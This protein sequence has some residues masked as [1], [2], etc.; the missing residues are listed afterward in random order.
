MVSTLQHLFLDIQGDNQDT[1][2]GG[3]PIHRIITLHNRGDRAAYLELWVEATDQR[4]AGIVQ[5]VTF[6]KSES[7]LTLEPRQS[8]DV[9]LTITVPLQAEAGFYGYDIRLRSS[10]YPGEEV[11]RNQ[12][13]HILPSDQEARL[14][15]EPHLTVTPVTDSDH[16][17]ML[18]SGAKLDLTLT[19]DNPS[20]RTDRFFLHCDNLPPDWYT[21]Q[22]PESDGA[23][24]GVITFTDGL[25]LNPRES[26]QIVMAIH[27]PQYSPAGSYYP[28]LRL[29]SR[30]RPEITLLKI[31]Y[32]TLAIDERLAV[33]L[34]PKTLAIPLK[35][36]YF[37]VLVHNR[38]NLERQLVF[39][40]RDP[41]RRLRYQL[42]PA[43]VRLT[44]GEEANL[45]LYVNPRHWWQKIWRLRDRTV[46]FEL[47]VEN[48]ATDSDYNPALPHPLPTGTVNLKARRRWLFWLLLLST[49]TTALLGLLALAWHMFVWRPSLVPKIASFSTTQ[50][51]YQEGKPE[52]ISFSWEITNP[53]KVGQIVLSQDG[54]NIL[55]L[56]RIFVDIDENF[57]T[58]RFDEKSVD[59]LLYPPLTEQGS[60]SLETKI[61]NPSPLQIL[62]R[63]YRRARRLP[64]NP[65]YLKCRTIVP[66]DFLTEELE[67]SDEAS[68]AT[69]RLPKEG[70]YEFQLQ[71]FTGQQLTET[72]SEAASETIKAGRFT[73]FK[74]ILGLG[75]P[76]GPQLVDT[77][78][79]EKVAVAAADPPEILEFKATQSDY[80]TVSVSTVLAE[81]SPADAQALPAGAQLSATEINNNADTV[82]LAE[83]TA[84]IDP[85]LVPVKLDWQI[86]NPDDIQE[87]RLTSL[88]PDGA[89]NTEAVS[90]P[91]LEENV[92]QKLLSLEDYCDIVPASPNTTVGPDILVCNDVPTQA[93]Q[94]G[95][96]VFYL[97]VV[98]R[99]GIEEAPILK[100]TP[101]I[102][103]K[104]PEP[105]IVDFAV[106]GE[107]VEQTPRRVYVLNPAR[108]KID[109]T[110]SWDVKYAELIELLPAP[111]KVVERVDEMV[112][113]LSAAPGA[114]TI[115]LRGVNE[116]D[117]EI[118]R[119][120]IIEKVA[121]EPGAQP[122]PLQ[123]SRRSS[124]PVD[125]GDVPEGL[126]SLPPPPTVLP[127][128]DIAPIRTPPQAN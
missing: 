100:T 52:P 23:V 41:D 94:V 96:Y 8:L 59:T 43:E 47:L 5:W 40:G 22:Y 75:E 85:Q 122:V 42:Q 18:Q 77:A 38:G 48:I 126:P 111:G 69:Q 56:S 45:Y 29:T 102:S 21:I 114:E 53:K 76:E 101:T 17:H 39:Q 25:Q 106:N 33:E 9:T 127:V 115:T 32:F 70:T 1:K 67:A 2:P 10:Q 92:E 64:A 68:I 74:Q 62:L 44:P 58:E 107:S 80:R 34:M 84:E 14:R 90:Y 110:L 97:T 89:E 103:I 28:T 26:G 125:A 108:G 6:N 123:S 51:T 86:S 27:P 13:L 3:E 112:Y 93:T 20:R 78:V 24:P 35:N 116:L 30:A 128:P 87:L 109:I 19:V 72:T 7:E 57:L 104:P 83:T 95:D 99:D 65:Q 55:Q 61:D 81:A 11:Q 88:S 4:S 54:T 119:S 16:P 98:T 63:V 71:V 31:V 117:E 15:S 60:C 37:E 50:E 12:Q 46:E 49:A 66:A 121:F 91:I 120:V 118:T 82:A 73:A 124:R 105:A 113:T 79:L 36:R